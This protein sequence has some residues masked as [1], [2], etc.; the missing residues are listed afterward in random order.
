MASYSPEKRQEMFALMRERMR[1]EREAAN[2][3]PPPLPTS[4]YR[5][6]KAEGGIPAHLEM[7][8]VEEVAEMLGVSRDSVTRWFKDRAVVAGEPKPGR[9]PKQTLLISRRDLEEWL[10]EHRR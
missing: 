3:A 6:Q 8:R 4:A 5:R 2:G 7:Y 10:E 1:L 9:R